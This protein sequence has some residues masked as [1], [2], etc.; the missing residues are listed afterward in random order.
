MKTHGLGMW[1]LMRPIVIIGKIYSTCGLRKY[2]NIH[3]R[4][5]ID[6][7]YKNK[8]LL[9]VN[10]RRGFLIIDTTNCIIF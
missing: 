1:I 5:C 8:I 3:I 9:G 2:C 7:I 10:N 6:S 4:I